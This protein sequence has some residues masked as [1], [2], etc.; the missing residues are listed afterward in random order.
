MYLFNKHHHTIRKNWARLQKKLIGFDIDIQGEIDESADIYLINHQSLLDIVALESFH[1][2]NLCWVA[3]KEIADL[4][5]FGHILR[6]P[7]MIAVDRESKKSLIKLISDA[8]QRLQAGRK[9]AMFPEGTRSNGKEILKFRVGAKM[10][11]EKLDLKV[12]PVVIQNTNA[13]L[14]SKKLEAQSGTVHVT[15]LPSFQ[16]E[17]KSEWFEKMREDMAKVFYS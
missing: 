1:P 2:H 8:K 10:L 4:P 3:K 15:F 6:A 11:V 13:I 16:P 5:L 14:D 12:Q 7:Q 17:K 9:I